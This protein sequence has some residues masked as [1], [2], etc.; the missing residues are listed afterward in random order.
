MFNKKT[1]LIISE[2]GITDNTSAWSAGL[3]PWSDIVEIKEAKNELKQKLLV[4]HVKNPE[5]YLPRTGRMG[6]ELNR[7]YGTPLV[8]GASVLKCEYGELKSA[9]DAAFADSATQAR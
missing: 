4:I 8:I 7:M 5:E 3:V 1:A 6:P 9:I 2:D